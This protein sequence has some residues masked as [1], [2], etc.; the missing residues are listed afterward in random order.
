MIACANP[1]HAPAAPSSAKSKKVNMKV[2]R[3]SRLLSAA[4][5]EIEIEHEEADRAFTEA[6]HEVQDLI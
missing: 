2:K 5:E 3:D 6:A 4:L 1:A